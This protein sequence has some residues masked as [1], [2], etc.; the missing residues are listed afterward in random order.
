MV[1]RDGV[2]LEPQRGEMF[3][4]P[5]GPGNVSSKDFDLFGSKQM[6]VPRI[7]ENGEACFLVSDL[8]PEGINHAD[9]TV[10]IR[11]RQRMVF[12]A[13]LKKFMDDN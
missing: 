5:K 10:R 9:A 1:R 11:T 4:V 3:I 12:V 2:W 8:C 13:A 6:C 7:A